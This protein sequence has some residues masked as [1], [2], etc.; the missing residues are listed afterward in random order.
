PGEEQRDQRG[1]E[2]DHEAA[3]DA[4]DHE[5]GQ[6]DVVRHRCHQQLLDAALK[7]LTEEGRHHVGVTVVHHR[8]HNETGHDELHVAVAAHGADPVADQAAEDDEVERDGDH[9]RHQSLHPDAQE[10]P[11]LAH[12]DGLEGDVLVAGGHTTHECTSCGFS[13]SDTNNCSSR[14]DLLRMLLIRIP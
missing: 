5:A 14:F 12:D 4:A 10:A 7:L 1:N 9:R 8:H 2:S 11:H 3:R 13:S 6:D